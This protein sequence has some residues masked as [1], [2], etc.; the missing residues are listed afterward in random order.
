[1]SPFRL[2]GAVIGLLA[3]GFSCCAY[4]AADAQT[5]LGAHYESPVPGRPRVVIFVHGFTGNA[6][7]TWRASNGTYFPSLF[8]KDDRIKQANVFVASYDT[9]WTKETGTIAK[10]ADKLF[11]QLDSFRVITDYKELVF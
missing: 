9:H 4:G 5:P 10:L 1:M 3:L 11:D 6:D 8:A 7:T 2:N